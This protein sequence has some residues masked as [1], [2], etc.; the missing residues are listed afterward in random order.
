[1]RGSWRKLGVVGGL[2]GVA[3]GLLVTVGRPVIRG[4]EHPQDAGTQRVTVDGH[5][6]GR[7]FQ[8][9]GAVS[10]GG[11]SRLLTDYPARQ[12]D[13]ILDY[14]FRPGY[15]A[16]LQVL[17]TEIGSD[18]DTTAGAEASHERARGQV[19]CTT[20]YEWWLMAQAVRRNPAIK[21]YALEWSQPAWVHGTWN[22]ANIGYLMADHR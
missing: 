18:T 5:D 9:V 16:S 15:G 6:T 2:V 21:L 1:M 19:E 20:G 12:R 8:G 11:S 10:A 22:Q 17:K 3:V 13:R 7:T 4:V 14:L